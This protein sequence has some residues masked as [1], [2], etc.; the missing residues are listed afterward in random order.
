MSPEFIERAEKL[1][2]QSPQAL[3]ALYAFDDTC[4][5]A[6]P[7]HHDILGYTANEMV[8]RSWKEFIAAEDHAHATLAGDDAILSGR[9]I[10]FTIQ[11]RAKTGGALTL[12]G[13]AWGMVDRETGKGCLAFNASPA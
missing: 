10:E 6:S 1:A 7:S 4:R 12:K 5:W 3:V 9:S 2:A 11:A 8:G 13:T